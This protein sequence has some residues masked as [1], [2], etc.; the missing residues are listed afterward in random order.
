[1]KDKTRKLALLAIL[2]VIAI[3]LQALPIKLG[4]FQGALFLIPVIIASILAGSA[5]GGIVGFASSLVILFN[6][7]AMFYFQYNALFTILTVVA[8]CTL[9]GVGAGYIYK[10]FK[11]KYTATALASISAP[12]IN[13]G[14]FIL[15]SYVFF[16]P[17][18]EGNY[19][20]GFWTALVAMIGINFAIELAVCIILSPAI[21]SI[22][23][24]SSK[25]GT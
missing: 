18:I 21:A 22:I 14:I 4:Y 20:K 19:G 6:G 24:F 25:Q 15:A 7:D 11:S 17:L 9:A 23:S 13:T 10:V 2:T 5:A 3:I 16:R 1:M 12:I 8:K